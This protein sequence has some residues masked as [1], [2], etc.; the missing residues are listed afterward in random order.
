MARVSNDV[1][2]FRPVPAG[3]MRKDIAVERQIQLAK[4]LEEPSLDVGHAG[5]R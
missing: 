2:G 4:G 5:K 3:Q 1:R